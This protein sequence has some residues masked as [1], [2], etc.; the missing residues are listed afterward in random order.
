MYKNNSYNIWHYPLI[1][2]FDEEP[3]PTSFSTCSS[4]IFDGRSREGQFSSRYLFLSSLVWLASAS[5]RCWPIWSIMLYR[6]GEFSDWFYWTTLRTEYYLSFIKVMQSNF[7]ISHFLNELMQ[8]NFF[9]SQ[10]KFTTF[11]WCLR[12]DVIFFLL[13]SERGNKYHKQ[14]NWRISIELETNNAQFVILILQ[15]HCMFF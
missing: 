5:S 15:R 4:C 11:R 6:N 9:V 3:K 2:Q 12:L 7:I 10:E 14:W 13:S 8:C 1:L